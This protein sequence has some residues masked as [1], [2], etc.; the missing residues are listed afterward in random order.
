MK[1]D[2]AGRL[3]EIAAGRTWYGSALAEAIEKP[4]LSAVEKA[5]LFRYLNGSNVGL[6][7]VTLQGIAISI[8]DRE[9]D[10]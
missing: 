1:I 2:L 4:Y 6:D 7:H 9:G 10:H 3:D 5:V 8:R